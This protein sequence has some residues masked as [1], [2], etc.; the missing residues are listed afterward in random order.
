MYIVCGGDVAAVG[1]N[2]NHPSPP[3]AATTIPSASEVSTYGDDD[4]VS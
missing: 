1:G 4:D 3:T 2:T